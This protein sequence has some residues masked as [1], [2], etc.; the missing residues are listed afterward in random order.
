MTVEASWKDFSGADFSAIHSPVN[1]DANEHLIFGAI[2]IATPAP[3]LAPEL[4]A[5][6][7]RWEGYDYSPPVKKDNKGVLVIQE[8]SPQGGKAFLWGATNLQFP[9]WVKEVQFKV[10]PGAVPAIEWQGDVTGVPGG[11]SGIFTFAFAVDPD[12]QVLK[13]GVNFRRARR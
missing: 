7:G 5:F 2:P 4:A 12:R 6:L 1:G 3:D 9:Y 13:G 8:I 10:V 11:A